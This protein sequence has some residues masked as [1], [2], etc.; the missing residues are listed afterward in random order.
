MAQGH[1]SDTAVVHTGAALL[2]APVELG[3]TGDAQDAYW[4]LVAYHSSLRELGRTVT[5][6]RDDINA[7][8]GQRCV[9]RTDLAATYDV[10]ELTSSVPRALQP[11]L[12][13]RLN[14][15]VRAGSA[16]DF[17]ASTNMLSVGVDVPRLGLMLVNGQPKAT[18]EYIQAT[19]R[20]G[21]ATA[22][23]LWSSGCSAQPSRATAR[24]TRPSA[25]T[26]RRSTATSSRRA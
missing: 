24:T 1:T 17:L 21:R 12:L 4:T 22:P 3:L 8:L 19:S 9:D 25:P 11:R 18:A 23:G 2:Q 20:V 15:P 5:I 10:E 26:T 16:I 14:L 6:A 7:R 13:E